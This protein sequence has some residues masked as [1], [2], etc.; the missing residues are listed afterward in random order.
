MT[1]IV[2]A[3]GTLKQSQVDHMKTCWRLPGDLEPD[4]TSVFHTSRKT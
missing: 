3:T 4:D 2:R 1:G